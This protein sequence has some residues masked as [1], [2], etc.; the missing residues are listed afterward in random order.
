MDSGDQSS[1][2]PLIEVGD[3]TE[4][5]AIWQTVFAGHDAFGRVAE[6]VAKRI[7]ADVELEQSAA[8]RRDKLRGGGEPDAAAQVM[9][10]WR[11]ARG[12]P[13]SRAPP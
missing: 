1:L 8:G 4:T 11:C 9:Q 13:P 6:R 7:L 3:E 10:R 2:T 12:S 5:G